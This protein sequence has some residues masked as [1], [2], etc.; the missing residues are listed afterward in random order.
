VAAAAP[1]RA[2]AGADWVHK[3]KHDGYR[4]QVLT[5]APAGVPADAM[6]R[7]RPASAYLEAE[8]AVLCFTVLA[9]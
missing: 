5:P 8:G 1:Y 4:L 6:R 3:I 9:R 2:P 7:Y